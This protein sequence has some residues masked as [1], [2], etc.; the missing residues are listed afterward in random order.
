MNP[1]AIL[2]VIASQG[3]QWGF[4]ENPLLQKFP[5]KFLNYEMKAWH[6]FIGAK[7][8]PTKHFATIDVLCGNLIRAIETDE[9][10]INV[11]KI[12]NKSIYKCMQTPHYGFYHL[13][14]ITELCGQAGVKMGKNEEVLKPLHVIDLH[15]IARFDRPPRPGQDAPAADD[16]VDVTTRFPC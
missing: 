2:R 7:L 16:N 5:T 15:T 14:L 1:D 13:S 4:N 10:T 3:G 6:R 9:D 8:M 12:I 11:G